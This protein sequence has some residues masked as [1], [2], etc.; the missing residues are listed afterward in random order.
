MSLQVV[1]KSSLR[2]NRR[3]NILLDLVLYSEVDYEVFVVDYIWKIK[4]EVF[5]KEVTNLYLFEVLNYFNDINFYL[6]V[7]N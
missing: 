3:N 7:N 2:F 1:K 4:M 6:K 5:L